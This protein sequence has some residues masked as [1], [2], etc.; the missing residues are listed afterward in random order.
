MKVK[1]NKK[2]TIIGIDEAGRGPLAGPVSVCA[3]EVTTHTKSQNA[4]YKILK[5]IKDSKKL[6][7]KQRDEWEKIIRKNF[8][9]SVA[10]VGPQ[11]I[12]RIGI[13][14]AT[15]L[16][17][18]RALQSVLSGKTPDIIFLD[19]LLKAPKQFNQK[20]ITKGDE[21]VPLIS[22]AS[23]IAKT[24]RDR[25]MQRL[26]KLYPEYCFDCHK[27]YGTKLHYKKIKKNGITNLH[28]KTYLKNVK[29][30]A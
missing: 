4:N 18:N 9:C 16:A 24:Y 1:A 12:D 2:Y 23:I 3:V 25:K 14:R 6:S 19:G 20:T 30:R 28:R 8:K 22:S 27:G 29:I 10:T 21:K 7:A 26:H 5:G 15:Q 11:I 13:K 17:V